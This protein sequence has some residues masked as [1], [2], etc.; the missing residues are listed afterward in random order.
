MKFY[1]YKTENNCQDFFKIIKIF[2]ILLYLL[3]IRYS[4][5]FNDNS[6]IYNHYTL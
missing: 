6:D 2:F 5:Y 1:F 4:L 3:L